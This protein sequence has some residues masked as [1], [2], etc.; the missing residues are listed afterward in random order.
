[1][2][3]AHRR[4][5]AVLH[6]HCD[7]MACGVAQLLDACGHHEPSCPHDRHRVGKLLHLAQDV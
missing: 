6:G 2:K 4:L 5:D 7:V 3:R 1:M